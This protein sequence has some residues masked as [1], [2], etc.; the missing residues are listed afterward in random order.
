MDI[1]AK[2][3]A[4]IVARALADRLD[5]KVV[6]RAGPPQTDGTNIFL[7]P[8]P[9]ESKLARPLVR[10][11]V[12]HE[13][14]HIR[15]SDLTVVQQT[16]ADERLHTLLN[17]IE[18]IR[19]EQAMMK[20]LPGYRGFV[21][22]G[23]RVA[24]PNLKTADEN[25][26]AWT[27]LTAF[28]LKVG[29]RDALQIRSIDAHHDVIDRLARAKFGDAF[30]DLVSSTALMART[31]VDT[32]DSLKVARRLLSILD[33][34]PPPPPPPP[35][36]PDQTAGESGDGAQ[37]PD[38]QSKGSG[39]A[40]QANDSGDSPSDGND[41]SSDQSTDS[42]ASDDG[43]TGAQGQGQQAGDDDGTDDANGSG[44]GASSPQQ[45][46]LDELKATPGDGSYQCIG[47]AVGELLAKEGKAASQSGLYDTDAM[48]F[49]FARPMRDPVGLAKVTQVSAKAR[50]RMKEQLISVRRAERTL[51][52]SGSR[53]SPARL[54]N[55]RRGDLRV[56]ERIT[57]GVN[58]N[59][60]V[61]VLLDTSGSMAD[62]NAIGVAREAAMALANAL[63]TIPGVSV[64][65]AGF[66]S[67][68]VYLPFGSSVPEYAGAM[69]QV[70]AGGGT[71]LA[72]GILGIAPALLSQTNP[73]KLLIVVSDGDP[74]SVKTAQQAL[75]HLQD[76]GV[77]LLG[78]GIN[79]DLSHLIE[80]SRT[81]TQLA[82]LPKAI[83]DAVSRRSRRSK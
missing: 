21:S 51:H 20:V 11:F 65:V 12:G 40:D 50:L 67:G 74:N 24:L 22:E 63:Y 70:Y 26:D 37:D 72:E 30:I 2:G 77:E 64:S 61:Q 69:S 47:D 57:E 42:S 39:D 25:S 14:S 54:M 46:A 17:I 28:L 8:L 36:E 71:P 83:F 53:I 80:D 48:N 76:F 59:C 3:A 10:W 1:I 55:L 32:A 23:M 7:P 44:K 52:R 9:I 41:A 4:P 35:A 56:F 75:A 60:A 33:N 82:E 19:I 5:V 38:E 34:P 73:R 49:D 79:M 15:H 81:I 68:M 6:F 66:P 45:D 43:D 78:I 29:Y 31:L 27:T 13:T 62:R 16:G 58:T 18:D